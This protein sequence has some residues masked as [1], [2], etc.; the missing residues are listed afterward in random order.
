MTVGYDRTWKAEEDCLVATVE[1]CL[2]V[3]TFLNSHIYASIYLTHLVW[4]LQLLL[5]SSLSFLHVCVQ[6]ATGYEDGYNRHLSNKGEV[7]VNGNT[8]HIAGTVSTLDYMY[9]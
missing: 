6:L 7:G 1:I 3:T 9:M 8:F 5:I 4:D 2:S